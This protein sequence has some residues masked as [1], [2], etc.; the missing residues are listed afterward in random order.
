[1]LGCEGTGKA[2]TFAEIC[3]AAILCGELSIVGAIA[4]GDFA[5]AHAIF[6]RRKEGARH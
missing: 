3:A 4:A 6:G 1:M 5:K 2:R